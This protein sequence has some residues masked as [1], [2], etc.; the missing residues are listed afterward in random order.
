MERLV[1]AIDFVIDI[2]GALGGGGPDAGFWRNAERIMVAIA[3]MVLSSV[4]CFIIAV[5]IM[6]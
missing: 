3:A 5:K 2:L 4:L 6:A 1:L